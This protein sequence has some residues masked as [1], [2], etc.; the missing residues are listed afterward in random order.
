MFILVGAEGF[1]DSPPY[2]AMFFEFTEH[3]SQ[4]AETKRFP[5]SLWLPLL[6][7]DSSLGEPISTK[8]GIT[9]ITPLSYEAAC[10]M[11]CLA[12]TW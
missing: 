2:S 11:Q 10:A 12:K 8:S 6:F 4:L 9:G 3:L 5:C 7:I 1:E